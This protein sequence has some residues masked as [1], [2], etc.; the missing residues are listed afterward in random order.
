[1]LAQ[2]YVVAYRAISPD[3]A[4][5]AYVRY[6]EAAATYRG[7][8]ADHYKGSD[9]YAPLLRVR[10]Q[11]LAIP[12][13]PYALGTNARKRANFYA[14]LVVESYATPIYKYR[15]LW[16]LVRPEIVIENFAKYEPGIFMPMAYL[17]AFA[18]CEFVDHD[19]API[20]KIWRR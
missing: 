1:M 19:H 20:W 16:L 12:F 10:Y 14:V 2:L 3:L 5:R 17:R 18:V 11:S 9:Y 13:C 8:W 4:A 15:L 6:A 7:A